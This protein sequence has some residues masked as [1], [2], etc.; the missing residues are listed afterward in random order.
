MRAAIRWTSSAT[1][2]AGRSSPERSGGDGEFARSTP[3][4]PHDPDRLASCASQ[5][6][7]SSGHRSGDK[8]YST[9]ATAEPSS[10]NPRPTSSGSPS[11]CASSA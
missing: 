2:L 10:R 6:G 11:S 3:P 4:D 7:F 5:C 8:M 9:V 1:M